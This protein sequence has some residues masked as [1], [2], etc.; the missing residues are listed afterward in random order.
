MDDAKVSFILK[1]R[2][3]SLQKVLPLEEEVPEDKTVQEVTIEM[4]VNQCG[5]TATK[6]KRFVT[7]EIKISEK[8]NTPES[9]EKMYYGENAMYKKVSALVIKYSQARPKKGMKTVELEAFD[10]DMERALLHSEQVVLLKDGVEERVFMYCDSLE[11]LRKLL[12]FCCV[13]KQVSNFEFAI[14]DDAK[15]KHERHKGVVDKYLNPVS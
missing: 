8:T 6:A 2:S 10:D 5:L 3:D 9:F 13:T 1:I 4:I 14:S 11:Q 12:T 7:E 15:T